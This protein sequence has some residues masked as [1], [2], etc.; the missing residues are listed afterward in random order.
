MR[1]L[2]YPPAKL[3]PSFRP[4]CPFCWLPKLIPIRINMN[5]Q[6]EFSWP[7]PHFPPDTNSLPIPSQRSPTG[8][9][10]EDDTTSCVRGVGSFSTELPMARR[11][12]HTRREAKCA[13][14]AEAEVSGSPFLFGG[15]NHSEK[16]ESQLGWLFPIYR[17]IENVPNHQPDFYSRKKKHYWYP[18]IEP[19]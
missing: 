5:Q 13:T 1:F 14:S 19:L 3:N 15:L 18:A 2:I 10:G 17:K 4:W 6:C 8:S 12:E 11:Q 7:I 9:P 16:Y